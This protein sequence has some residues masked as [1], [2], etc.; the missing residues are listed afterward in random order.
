MSFTHPQTTRHTHR[1]RKRKSQ[2][3]KHLFK[4]QKPR[5]PL[6]HTLIFVIF[7]SFVCSSLL[8]F[9]SPLRPARANRMHRIRLYLGGLPA[10]VTDDE[11]RERFE[12]EFGIVHDIRI[13]PAKAESGNDVDRSVDRSIDQW[14]DGCPRLFF[15]SSSSSSS[16]ATREEHRAACRR[17]QRLCALRSDCQERARPQAMPRSLFGLQVAR[18]SAAIEARQRALHGQ[19]RAGKGRGERERER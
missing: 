8:L 19:A 14:M 6:C 18:G 10:D 3:N 1:K 9:F 4:K 17:M 16:S 2:T 5:T 13:A 12:P 15:S 11:I 7:R